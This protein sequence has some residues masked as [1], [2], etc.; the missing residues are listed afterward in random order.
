[1][2]PL[3]I[4]RHE[5]RVYVITLTSVVLFHAN[6]RP[7]TFSLFSTLV[8]FFIFFHDYFIPL[9]GNIYRYSLLHFS[10][11]NN[12]CLNLCVSE[13]EGGRKRK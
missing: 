8:I 3:K 1:M 13:T 2:T 6:T 4:C 11:C 12:I 10:P 7:I 9:L 5:Y